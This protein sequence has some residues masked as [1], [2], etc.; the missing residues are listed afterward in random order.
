MIAKM[1]ENLREANLSNITTNIREIFEKIHSSTKNSEA[2]VES[3]SNKSSII[4]EIHS[5]TENVSTPKY[6]FCGSTELPSKYKDLFDVTKPCKLSLKAPRNHNE[7]KEALE[8]LNEYKNLIKV[9]AESK[10]IITI[11][12]KSCKQLEKLCSILAGKLKN[13]KEEINIP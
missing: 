8:L 13:A 2:K 9:D 11:E 7:F 1:R 5:G 12:Q 3:D 4:N 10:Q 6:A